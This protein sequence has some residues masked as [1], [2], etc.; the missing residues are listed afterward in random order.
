MVHGVQYHCDVKSI[1]CREN[2]SRGN[3]G[4]F[5]FTM[6]CNSSNG[7]AREEETVTIR[8]TWKTTREFSLVIFCDRNILRLCLLLQL[9]SFV[10]SLISSYLLQFL[11]AS[12]YVAIAQPTL[13]HSLSPPLYYWGV[14][15][16]LVGITDY[17]V[18]ITDYLVVSYNYSWG[19]N[20][21]LVI[22]FA[23]SYYSCRCD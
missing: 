5:S 16:S 3:S 18:G 9:L 15:T 13:P 1:S 23:P 2:L 12:A 19:V 21:C 8:H 14:K 4:G 7:Y 17:L 11:L 20:N 10:Y 22:L 6:H